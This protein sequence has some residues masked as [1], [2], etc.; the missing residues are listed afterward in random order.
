MM[1]AIQKRKV[2]DWEG[3]EKGGQNR[4][5]EHRMK[6]SKIETKIPLKKINTKMIEYRIGIR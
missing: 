1:G 3:D 4:W 5:I 2:L 6:T